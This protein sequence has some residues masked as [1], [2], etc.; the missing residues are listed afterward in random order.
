MK[1]RTC[2][3]CEKTLGRHA[4]AATI[5]H[6]DAGG[7]TTEYSMCLSCIQRVERDDLFSQRMDRKVARLAGRFAA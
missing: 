5:R 7:V 2:L 6:T 3:G 1:G 4:D